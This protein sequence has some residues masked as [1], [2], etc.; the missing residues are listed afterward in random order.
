MAESSPAAVTAAGVE[1]VSGPNRDDTR[2]EAG[3]AGGET[4]KA[5]N[6]PL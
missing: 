2:A 6:M 4:H 5:Y 3:T 1:V